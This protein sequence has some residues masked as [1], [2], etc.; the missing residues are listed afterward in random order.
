[1]AF[2]DTLPLAVVGVFLLVPTALGQLLTM[3]RCEELGAAGGERSSLL[4]AAEIECWHGEHDAWAKLAVFA[5]LL[6]GLCVPFA[7]T[8][9]LARQRF[10]LNKNKLRKVTV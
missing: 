7:A 9:L 6:W 2:V 5:V 8:A 4:A 10:K 1:M 3:L